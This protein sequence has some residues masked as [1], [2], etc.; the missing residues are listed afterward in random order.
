MKCNKTDDLPCSRCQRAMRPCYSRQALPSGELE[1]VLKTPQN[2]NSANHLRSPLH[3]HRGR[4]KSYPA[5]DT[6]TER[7]AGT[8]LLRDGRDSTT[9]LPSIYSIAPF[10]AVLGDGA[11][12]SVGDEPSTEASLSPSSAGNFDHLSSSAI[13]SGDGTIASG[14]GPELSRKEM[15]QLLKMYVQWYYSLCLT[16]R[17]KRSS[18]CARMLC[19]I[20]ILAK[21]DFANPE[22]LIDEHPEVVHSI[23]YVTSRYL[24]GG[25]P[26]VQC[27]YPKVLQFIQ[28]K[29]TTSSRSESTDMWTFRALII[30]YAFSEAGIPG[31]QSP[32][33]AFLL[34]VQLL[35]SVTESFG[36]QLGLHRSIDGVKRLMSL[37]HDQWSSKLEYKRYTYWLWLFTM[38]HQ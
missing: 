29:C 9:A 4:R 16:A 25:L 36:M 5:K 14:L 15:R 7:D 13:L 1:I 35:K 23:C 33:S 8:T 32:H 2:F 26:T 27:V 17:A 28:H 11:G 10:T 6:T 19:S 30:L 18:F 24:A 12:D 3:R 37:S 21:E 22:F 38:S 31:T 34:P 20:P